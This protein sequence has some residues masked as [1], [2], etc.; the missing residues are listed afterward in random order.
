MS[1]TM[2][3]VRAVVEF[4]KANGFPTAKLLLWD[5]SAIQGIDDIPG[6]ESPEDAMDQYGPED[7]IQE[8]TP[9]LQLNGTIRLG[10]MGNEDEDN[11]L[12]EISVPGDAA[13]AF[14]AAF[15]PGP[16]NTTPANMADLLSRQMAKLR[17]AVEQINGKETENGK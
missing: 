13:E 9:G 2:N 7:G 6:H 12:K 4:A 14:R 17:E 11:V 3:Q 15:P 5:D 8:F 1:V 16:A 10:W